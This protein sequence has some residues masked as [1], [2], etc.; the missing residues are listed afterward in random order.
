MHIT[1]LIKSTNTSNHSLKSTNILKHT[2]TLTHTHTHTNTHNQLIKTHTRI[3]AKINIHITHIIKTQT[4]PTTLS[5]Q[6]TNLHTHSHKHT[7]THT[8]PPTNTHTHKP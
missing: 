1:H 3:N 7:H 8:K 2:N 5:N 4:Y 6:P